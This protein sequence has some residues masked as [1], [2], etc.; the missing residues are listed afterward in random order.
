MQ[1]MAYRT[2]KFLYAGE[3]GR[4][5]GF[6]RPDTYAFACRAAWR[7]QYA[8]THTTT[9]ATPRF[10]VT[11]IERKTLSR[12]VPRHHLRFGI[13]RLS[14]FVEFITFPSSNII[15]IRRRKTENIGFHH[16]QLPGA[17]INPPEAR[18]FS[19]FVSGCFHP[20]LNSIPPPTGN[21]VFILPYES[22]EM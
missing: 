3:T 14:L 12:F 20:I 4:S 13:L 5:I 15:S 17:P 2:P 7:F 19:L 22:F 10:A 16:A 9:P 21:N 8:L 6:S 11:A 1:Y 18:V